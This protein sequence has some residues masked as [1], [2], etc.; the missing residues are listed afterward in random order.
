MEAQRPMGV[1]IKR[2]V[3]Q[4]SCRVKTHLVNNI[5]SFALL[6]FKLLG[7]TTSTP[8]VTENSIQSSIR[9]PDSKELIKT[10]P[11]TIRPRHRRESWHGHS[12]LRHRNRAL[13]T[14]TGYC[15]GLTAQTKQPCPG[16]TPTGVATSTATFGIFH[17]G[18]KS[19]RELLST[20]TNTVRNRWT[21]DGC[22]FLDST[23]S[24]AEPKVTYN[25]PNL[26]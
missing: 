18:P 20:A 2:S 3:A 4:L 23:W 12:H 15:A 11:A 19:V 10:T 26:P 8:Q 16:G 21:R 22:F 13:S 14:G 25:D 17:L 5:H 7:K 24:P 6:S 9:S 1:G